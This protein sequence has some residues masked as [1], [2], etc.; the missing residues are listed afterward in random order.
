MYNMQYCYMQYRM[1]L[2]TLCPYLLTVTRMEVLTSVTLLNMKKIISVS[3]FTNHYQAHV[4]PNI[5][6]IM[7]YSISQFM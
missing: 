7:Q 2:I 4:Q 1:T 3:S 5:Y 6:R